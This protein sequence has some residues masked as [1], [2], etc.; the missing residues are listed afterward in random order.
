[1]NACSQDAVGDSG[2][3]IHAADASLDTS[4]LACDPATSTGCVTCMCSNEGSEPTTGTTPTLVSTVSLA[5]P[6]FDDEFPTND[7]G[8]DEH[9][10]A[11]GGS[12]DDEKGNDAGGIR[13]Y[14]MQKDGSW[15]LKNSI[16]SSDIRAGD[17]FGARLSLAG[18]RLVADVTRSDAT[19]AVSHLGY[20]FEDKGGVWQQTAKLTAAAGSGASIH[21]LSRSGAL[22]AELNAP[23]DDKGVASA[24][25]RF[26]ARKSDGSWHTSATTVA[27]VDP[28]Q[29]W[30]R[31]VSFSE[32]R[33]VVGGEG[34][35]REAEPSG[36]KTGAA[37]IFDRDAA[38]VW[39]QVAKVTPKDGLE[40]DSFGCAVSADAD[41]LVVGAY[42]DNTLAVRAGA[43]YA[44]RR[45]P[46]G[47]WQQVEK[48]TAY[49][50]KFN[51]WFGFSVATRG[52]RL[53]VGAPGA[54]DKEAWTG[55]VYV[56]RLTA[57]GTWRST[58]KIEGTHAVQRTGAQIVFGGQHVFASA[59]GYYGGGGKMTWPGDYPSTPRAV[60][61]IALPSFAC[62]AT[63]KCHCKPGFTGVTCSAAV[64]K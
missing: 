44:F 43:A 1:M 46:S 19:G 3:D 50:G 5:V 11:V 24:N 55:A 10:L 7:L 12:Y 34:T 27:A 53:L 36:S 26:L 45:Q 4:P 42:R 16:F 41:R 57:T 64:G 40:H 48:L 30:S 17:R 49:D 56:Y 9:W 54:D 25:V 62:D 13:L 51:A 35:W 38:G 22:M 18:G 61:V 20:V 6:G 14:Q 33:L 58:G 39:A 47:T 21:T 23:V 31:A 29:T 37:Y 8:A 32:A 15:L 63:G 60:H 28:G 52:D 2:A 59:A